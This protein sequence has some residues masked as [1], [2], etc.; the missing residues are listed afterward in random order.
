[1]KY[2]AEVKETPEGELYF[3]LPQDL[4]DGL[5]WYEGDVI[6]WTVTDTGAIIE[7]LQANSGES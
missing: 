5:G 3:E 2:T 7:K 4:L 6:R 1:M